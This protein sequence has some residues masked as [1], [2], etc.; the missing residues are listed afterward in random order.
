MKTPHRMRY[1]NL[2][3]RWQGNVY[4][5][6]L[7][8]IHTFFFFTPKLFLKSVRMIPIFKKRLQFLFSPLNRPL[9]A[10]SLHDQPEKAGGWAATAPPPLSHS[11][12]MEL[13]AGGPCCQSLKMLGEPMRGSSHPFHVQT[14]CRRG[15]GYWPE[16]Q[17]YLHLVAQ[18]PNVHCTHMSIISEISHWYRVPSEWHCTL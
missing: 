17:F 7:G 11:S 1:S 3:W 14:P 5:K 4:R 16:I 6:Y 8:I 13:F 15:A 18:A 10:L 12:C 9:A 2:L